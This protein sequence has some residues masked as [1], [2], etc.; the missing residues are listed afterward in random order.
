M[1]FSQA[2]DAGFKSLLIFVGVVFIWL[3]FVEP[4]WTN[5]TLS[6]PV[7][8]VIALVAAAAFFIR[9]RRQCIV[10]HRTADAE[11]SAIIAEDN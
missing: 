1:S 7:M 10:E 4:I 2:W 11:V 9:R 6:T 5:R 3:I 8:T